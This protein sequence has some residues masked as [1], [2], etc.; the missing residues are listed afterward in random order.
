MVVER[1]HSYLHNATLAPPVR[2][3]AVREGAS[4]ERS[5]SPIQLGALNRYLGKPRSLF[6][7]IFPAIAL[8]LEAPFCKGVS[9]D[10]PPS[11]TRRV[12]V[13]LCQRAVSPQT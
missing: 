4:V 3:A 7:I 2:V 10:V 13:V 9:P 12:P 6:G 5:A 8:V 11:N 1:H